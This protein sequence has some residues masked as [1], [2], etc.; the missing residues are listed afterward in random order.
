MKTDMVLYL[1]ARENA[2]QN[3]REIDEICL[4]NTENQIFKKNL[5]KVL[6]KRR[7]ICY[8]K[9]VQTRK[10]MSLRLYLVN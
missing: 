1:S 7:K 8:Y 2:K 6:D 9:R 3:N 10:R 5:K 4:E